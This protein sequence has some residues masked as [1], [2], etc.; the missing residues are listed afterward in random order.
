MILSELP[1]A[2]L[3]TFPDQMRRIFRKRVALLCAYGGKA[4]KAA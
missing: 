3:A 1:L 2:F 4:P